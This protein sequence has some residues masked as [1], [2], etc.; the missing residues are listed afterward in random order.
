MG[1]AAG[2]SAKLAFVATL[3]VKSRGLG[4][5]FYGRWRDGSRMIERPVGRGWLVAEG[6]R[7]ARPNGRTI[8]AF[9][10]RAG[11]PPAGFLTIQAATQAL[12]ALEQ[13]WREEEDRA[14]LAARR[15]GGEQLTVAELAERYLAWGERDDPHT[16]RDGWKHSHARNTRNY[17]NRLVRLLGA[18]RPISELGPADLT[19]VMHRL[20]PERN[21]K[22]TGARPS[23]KFL[24]TYALPLKG[25]FALAAREGWTEEDVARELP[26]Y[27]PKRKRAADPMRRDEYLTPEEVAAVLEQLTD[28][29]DRAMVTVMAMGGMRPGEMLA[30]R[31]QDVD[32]AGANLRIVESRTMGVTGTT[33]SDIGRSVPMPPEAAQAIAKVGLRQ[34][35]LK[36]TDLVFIGKHAGH[37]DIAALRARF[38]AAQDQA[39]VIPRRELRQLRNTFGTVCASAGV[40]LRTI[41][42]WMGHEN[43]ATTERYA[44]HMPRSKD[45][46]LISAAFA[47]G[48]AALEATLQRGA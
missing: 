35:L 5:M 48:P 37:V 28:H 16:D 21:G 23:R 10:E 25:M 22:P 45:A 27:K 24:S 33:K 17:V 9:R 15:A 1:H 47:V 29:Q 7:G 11:R 20:V 12:V 42:Q 32:L 36:R 41:Q 8:G 18:E 4:P 19:A 13:Q 3:R 14:E 31:W 26:S 39:G 40:P 2:R 44:S 43:I 46:A 38:N 34:V 30:L 6:E